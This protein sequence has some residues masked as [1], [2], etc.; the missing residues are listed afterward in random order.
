MT[1]RPPER[2][3]R[4]VRQSGARLIAL[5]SFAA[6]TGALH[7][8]DQG[9]P[10][11]FAA[12]RAFYIT[13]MPAGANR[14]G[15]A[16]KICEQFLVCLHG[17]LSVTVDDGEKRS[18]FRLDAPGTGLYLPAMTWVEF[19]AEAA[20]SVCLVLA[21]HPYDEDDYIR[22]RDAFHPAA[23]AASEGRDSGR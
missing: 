16:H 20:D 9:G 15:H 10:V 23:A 17:S 4:P 8:F 11:P 7:V 12:R 21:S 2:T 1:P 5:P 13:G 14:G 6:A 22:D 19:K 3:A 18:E